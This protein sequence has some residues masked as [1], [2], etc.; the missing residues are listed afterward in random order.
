MIIAS[1]HLQ[2]AR[3]LFIARGRCFF[4]LS[5]FLPLRHSPPT[6]APVY[7]SRNIFP[8]NYSFFFSIMYLFKKNASRIWNFRL[9]NFLPRTLSMSLVWSWSA[10]D[11]VIVSARDI[12]LRRLFQ[13]YRTSRHPR[14]LR[15]SERY[16]FNRDSSGRTEI[17]STYWSLS[18]FFFFTTRFPSCSSFS[19][20]SHIQLCL[21]KIVA[22]DVKNSQYLRSMGKHGF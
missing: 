18:L 1:L 3:I 15:L 16:S 14:N 22:W 9:A 13:N 10:Y 4:P 7:N 8:C 17:S 2:S 6:F 20:S 19:Y 5:R 11:F 12:S 21:K